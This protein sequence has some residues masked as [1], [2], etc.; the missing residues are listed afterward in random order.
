VGV[1]AVNR[2]HAAER[3]EIAGRVVHRHI[4]IDAVDRP[5]R[6]DTV[7]AADAD[8]VAAVVGLRRTGWRRRSIRG[9]DRRGCWN[10]LKAGKPVTKKRTRLKSWSACANRSATKKHRYPSQANSRPSG[11]GTCRK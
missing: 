1:E 10:K 2:R 6:Q 7:F 5:V 3:D 8:D 4:V 9:S 11:N